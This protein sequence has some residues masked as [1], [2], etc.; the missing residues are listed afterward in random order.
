MASRYRRAAAAPRIRL[1]DV[2]FEE[3]RQVLDVLMAF[4]G[5]RGRLPDKVECAVLK[6][7]EEAFGS[8]ARA[9]AVIKRVTGKERWEEISAERAQ[10][11]LIYLALIR[12]DGRPKFSGLSAVLQKDVRSLFGTYKRACELADVMLYSAGKMDEINEACR[13]A[14]VGKE[15][16]TAL[17]VH[18]SVLQDLPPILRIYEGCARAYIGS[19]EGANVIKLN[20]VKPQVSYLAYPDFDK[21]AHPELAYSFV[22]KLQKLRFK[23]RDFRDSVNP[24][25]LHRKETFV[26]ADYQ[27]RDKFAKLT[28]EEERKGLYEDTSRIGLLDGWDEVLEEKGVV[29]KGHRVLRK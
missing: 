6:S 15:T 12:F 17:Y 20:R 26:G 28:R 10:D 25:I 29:I 1:S 23:V 16:P 11:F 9:F 22:V 5:E 18:E 24:P 3:H 13:N 27:G 19:V 7:V 14:G 4:Y 21:K 8:I 2:L